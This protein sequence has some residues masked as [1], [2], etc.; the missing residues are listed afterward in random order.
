MILVLTTYRTGSTWY[1]DN[2]ARTRD[3]T[4]LGEAF[5]ESNQSL[6]QQVV[7]YLK[8]NP[9][10]VVKLMPCHLSK[11]PVKHL[12]EI[13]LEL[14]TEV[15]FLVRNNFDAQCQSYYIAKTTGDWHNSFEQHIQVYLDKTK[16]QNW[17]S[18]LHQQYLELSDIY[19]QTGNATLVSTEQLHP[20]GKY[21]RPVVWNKQPGFTNID[22]QELFE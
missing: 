10:T 20:Q 7:N 17:V 18:F 22:I 13:L 3:Y 1:C 15:I 16:W 19:S 11:T 8:S 9:R 14:A 2:I 5:H 4:N 12:L 6:H 21:H